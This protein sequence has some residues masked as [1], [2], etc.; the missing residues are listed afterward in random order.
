M[1]RDRL[2]EGLDDS[3]RAAVASESAPLCVHAG[4][5][6]GKTRVLTR[7]VAHRAE[8][9]DLDPRHTLV[10]TFTRKA[11]GELRQRLW[12]LGLR[13]DVAAGTFHAT[14][15]AQ[16]RARW[17]ERRAE[18]PR[19]LE[20]KRRFV[21]DLLGRRPELAGAVLAEI[22]WAT[23][24]LIAPDD[25]AERAARAGRRPPLPAPQVADLMVRYADAKTAARLVDFDDL[26][27]FA[28]QVLEG[29]DRAAAALRWRFR[30]LF[31]DEF[32]DV[33]PLQHRLLRAWLGEGHDLFVVGDP[34][35]AIYGWNGADAR[36]L[37]R[38][39]EVYP[40]ERHPDVAV[41]RLADNY[42][43]SPE[44]LAVAAAVLDTRRLRPHRPDGPLPVVVDHPDE[45][46]EAEAIARDVRDRHGPGRPWSSQAVLVRTNAQ[47]ALI[48]EALGRARIPHRLR[49]ADR[50]LGRPV[51]VETLRRLRAGSYDEVLAE[52]R[53]PAEEGSDP[54]AA[55]DRATLV[56]LAREYEALDAVPTGPGFANWLAAAVRAG[57]ARS[58]DAVEV[59]TFHAAKGL[60]WPVVHLAGL[61][62]GLVPIGWA[63]TP[64]AEAEERRLL[65]VAVTR[66]E[67]ELRLHWAR[68]R[69]PTTGGEARPRSPSPWLAAIEGA[70]GRLAEAEAPVDGRHHLRPQHQALRA[71]HPEDHD[72]G[73]EAL[74]RLRAWRAETAR[75]ARIDPAAVVDDP[76]LHAI[77]DADPA[78]ADEL[79]A[80]PGLGPVKAARL[81]PG[82]LAAL[83]DT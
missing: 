72:A 19:L 8:R 21:A 79:A 40:R 57:D 65:Y 49:G 22:D 3:Q 74:G 71:R 26:L 42:R 7:R 82:L 14:A 16:L 83:H 34:H 15:Y 25:Y 59:C 46:A 24:R 41:L 5:G 76:T 17:A 77:V 73:T 70:I 35:Q 39:E 43:S 2:L 4:A 38:F 37:D 62:D 69:T 10:L 30:H 27:R 51:V 68:Q 36:Y 11:A 45:G 63:T 61:E 52:L 32:Q 33:N 47:A 23:A 1:A 44:V 13:D 29:D 67:E 80:V 53:A 50:L 6:S 54:D 12:G 18:P 55:E 56:V 20:H 28:T 78:S 48:G 58:G 66:A 75:A 64:E 81:A 31:V 60:E 9:G